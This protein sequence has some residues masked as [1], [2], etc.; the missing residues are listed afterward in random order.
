MSAEGLQDSAADPG[1]RLLAAA[2]RDWPTVLTNA[3]RFLG[4]NP[5]VPA[6][7]RYL[8][9]ASEATGQPDVAHFTIDMIADERCV[10]LKSLK[11]YFWSYRDEGAFHEKVTNAVLDD[12]VEATAPRFVRVSARW[13]VRGGIYTDVVAEYRKKGWKPAAALTL[14][15]AAMATGLAGA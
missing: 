6:P 1:I 5:L 2:V 3:N 7:Y 8:A 4:V 15:P 14:P 11:M 10:E 13:N 9:E 12:I